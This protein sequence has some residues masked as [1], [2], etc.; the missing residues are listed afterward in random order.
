MEKI[1]LTKRGREILLL[2]K[3]NRYNLTKSD[4]EEL[5]LLTVEGLGQGTKAYGDSYIN[6]RLT[7]KGRAYL[8]SNPQLKNPSI[9]DDKKYII[10]TGVAIIAL[11][12][13]IL[14][15]FKEQIIRL[16]NN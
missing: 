12:I 16:W 3:E 10:T 5:N 1:K 11:F 7:D 6:Y 15:I 4:Y 2:I 13:S 14:S 9:W 8:L